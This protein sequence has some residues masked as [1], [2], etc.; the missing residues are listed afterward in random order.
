MFPGYG[1]MLEKYGDLNHF[2]SSTRYRANPQPRLFKTVMGFFRDSVSRFVQSGKHEEA[3]RTLMDKYNCDGLHILFDVYCEIKDVPLNNC[4]VSTLVDHSPFW[5]LFIDYIEEHNKCETKN[6]IEDCNRK[7][8]EELERK[9]K[10]IKDAIQDLEAGVKNETFSINGMLHFFEKLPTRVWTYMSEMVDFP[11]QTKEKIAEVDDRAKKLHY[12]ENL[13]QFSGGLLVED[14]E[15]LSKKLQRFSDD[16]ETLKMSVLCSDDYFPHAKVIDSLVGEKLL[17]TLDQ[18]ADL[19]KSRIWDSLWNKTANAFWEDNCSPE[20][21][22]SVEDI[23]EEIF[24]ETFD[25]W[26]KFRMQVIAKQVTFS[27]L[28]EFDFHTYPLQEMQNQLTLLLRNPPAS[29]EK[30]TNFDEITGCLQQFRKL[31]DGMD[32]LLDVVAFLS[33]LNLLQGLAKTDKSVEKL[34]KLSM[35]YQ[36]KVEWGKQTLGDV[37]NILEVMQEGGFILK[38]RGKQGEIKKKYL[39]LLAKHPSVVDFLTQH[40][41]EEYDDSDFLDE[42]DQMQ[43][44]AIAAYKKV[45]NTI[46][47]FILRLSE[48]SGELPISSLEEFFSLFASLR[49]RKNHLEDLEY[50]AN[51]ESI[52]AVK[53]ILFQLQH[54]STQM[55]TQ[56]MNE[57]MKTGT[58]HLVHPEHDIPTFFLVWGGTSQQQTYS[59]KEIEDL[60]NRLSL[61]LKGARMTNEEV[62]DRDLRATEEHKE[63]IE[64]LSLQYLTIQDI[65]RV[66]TQLHHMGNF[67]FAKY[68]EEFGVTEFRKNWRERQGYLKNE[69]DRWNLATKTILSGYPYLTFLS[70]EHWKKV[71]TNIINYDVDSAKAVMDFLH[72]KL[73]D[74]TGRQ[75]TRLVYYYKKQ[76]EV[77][78]RST[79]RSQYI[80]QQC[81]E[82]LDAVANI[83]TV[84]PKRRLRIPGS[85]K[86]KFIPLQSGVPNVILTSSALT[87]DI[88]TTVYASGG[89]VPCHYEIIFCSQKTSFEEVQALL[90]RFCHKE[91]KHNEWTERYEQ[92]IYCIVNPQELLLSIQCKLLELIQQICHLREEGSAKQPEQ[93]NQVDNFLVLVGSQKSSGYLL[94]ALNVYNISKNFVPLGT[95]DLHA[96]YNELAAQRYANRVLVFGSRCP[97]VGKSWN[98]RQYLKKHGCSYVHIPINSGI[99]SRD[100]IQL[101]NNQSLQPQL[102]RGFH[103]D[104]APTASSELNFQLYQLL[105]I[106][107]IA[108]SSD[109]IFSP[110]TQDIF[111]IELA[112]P[113]ASSLQKF[114]FCRG[115]PMRELTKENTL[116]DASDRTIQFVCQFLRCYSRH[117]QRF[118]ICDLD[119][120]HDVSNRA[121]TP[122]S[123]KKCWATLGEILAEFGRDINEDSL[124]TTLNFVRFLYQQFKIFSKCGFYQAEIM[125]FGEINPRL[126]VEVC[127]SL[128]ETAVEITNKAA[129]TNS[130]EDEMVSGN[131]QVSFWES[132]NHAMLLFPWNDRE[133]QSGSVQVVYKDKKLVP[134]SWLTIFKTQVLNDSYI[135]LPDYRKMDE[136]AL[137]LF[138]SEMI[139]V[140]NPKNPDSSYALT[141]DN[142]LKMIAIFIRVKASIPVIVMGDTGVGKSALIQ[143]LCK[144]S[145]IKFYSLDVHGGTTEDTICEF[146]QKPIKRAKKREVWVFFDEI[147]TCNS[148]G[149]FKQILCDHC[150]YGRP[151]P[152]NLKILA[153][154]NPYVERNYNGK[155]TGLVFHHDLFKQKAPSGTKAEEAV[156][157]SSKMKKLVYRVH[158]LPLTMVEYLWHYGQLEGEEERLYI[159]AMIRQ[160]NFTSSLMGVFRDLISVSQEFIRRRSRRQ[161]A[162]LYSA[163]LVVSMRDVRRCIQLYAW[164]M[165]NKLKLVP[166]NKDMNFTVL[167]SMLHALAICYHSRLLEKERFKYRCRITKVFN[168]KATCGLT[169]NLEGEIDGDGNTFKRIVETGQ[170]SFINHLQLPKGIAPNKA[171]Q[172]NI[173]CLAVCILNSIPIFIVG[174]PGSSKSLSMSLLQNNLNGRMSATKFLKS[175]PAVNV[176]SYQCSPLS[177]AEGIKESINK[178]KTMQKKMNE[179]GNDS[180]LYVV[181][182]DEI[183]LAEH[184][185]HLPLKVLHQLLEG[186][187]ST[188]VPVVGLTNWALDP[189]KMNRAIYIRRPEPDEKDLHE[190]AKAIVGASRGPA[191]PELV[192]KLSRL[193]KGYLQIYWSQQSASS[194]D[195]KL[196][197][198]HGLRDF[199]FFVKHIQKK[200]QA[201]QTFDEAFVDGIARNFGGLNK[202]KTKTIL[203]IFFKVIS[204]DRIPSQSR[205]LF[206]SPLRLIKENCVD[207]EGRHLMVISRVNVALNILSQHEIISPDTTDIIFGSSFPG[208]RNDTRI[209]QDITQIKHCMEVGRQ[210]VL[211]QL[212][213]LYESLYDMLNQ[214]YSRRAGKQFCRIAIGP[215]S[216]RCLVHEK[217]RLIVVAEKEDIDCGKLPPPLLNRFEKQRL[218]F[219]DLLENEEK[220]LVGSIGN[221][222][223]DYVIQQDPGKKFSFIG[224]T[225]DNVSS[226][227]IDQVKKHCALAK[228][229]S[230]KKDTEEVLGEKGKE[231]EFLISEDVDEPGKEIFLKCLRELLLTATPDGI[232][233]ASHTSPKFSDIKEIYFLEQPH[234]SLQSLF[235]HIEK[236]VSMFPVHEEHPERRWLVLSF[237]DPT[238][239][240]KLV[241]DEA[242]FL[243]LEDYSREVDFTFKIKTFFSDLSCELEDNMHKNTLIIQCVLADTP[244]SVLWHT[245]HIIQN[246]CAQNRSFG[247]QAVVLF[248]VHTNRSDL[249]TLLIPH[250]PSWNTILISELKQCDIPSIPKMLGLDLLQLIDNQEGDITLKPN[251]GFLET[252]FLNNFRGCL[253][254][255]NYPNMVEYKDQIG[256]LLDLLQND[257]FF[258]DVLKKRV[259]HLLRQ[260]AFQLTQ[261][262]QIDVA[263]DF[264]QIAI[265]GSYQKALWSKIVDQINKSLAM[266][267][268]HSD[269]NFN[270]SCYFDALNDN[271]AGKIKLWQ[272]LFEDM[273]RFESSKMDGYDV[274]TDG[275]SNF[276]HGGFFCKFPFSY[277]FYEQLEGM[278]NELTICSSAVPLGSQI[279]RHQL[280]ELERLRKAM[281]ESYPDVLVQVLQQEQCGI[282]GGNCLTL[283]YLHDFIRMCNISTQ[284]SDFQDLEYIIQECLIHWHSVFVTDTLPGQNHFEDLATVHYVFW[285]CE[286]KVRALVSLL[287]AFVWLLPSFFDLC[288]TVGCDSNKKGMKGM[289]EVGVEQRHNFRDFLGDTQTNCFTSQ[290]NVVKDVE[291]WHS[292]LSEVLSKLFK[293]IRDIILCYNNEQV[294]REIDLHDMQIWFGVGRKGGVVE[295]LLD[296]IGNKKLWQEWKH[297]VVADK[298]FRHVL[299]PLQS[300]VPKIVETWHSVVLGGFLTVE[301]K[302]RNWAQIVESLLTTNNSCLDSIRSLAVDEASAMIVEQGILTFLE[303]MIDFTT[304]TFQKEYSNQG[305]AGTTTDTLPDEMESLVDCVLDIITLDVMEPKKDKT[306]KMDKGK[307][308]ALDNGAMRI[309]M[310]NKGK[311]K[312]SQNKEYFFKASP[313][314]KALLLHFLLDGLLVARSKVFERLEAVVHSCGYQHQFCLLYVQYVEDLLAHEERTKNDEQKG[315][316]FVISVGKQIRESTLDTLTIKEFLELI[317]KSRFFVRRFVQVYCEKTRE[318]KP[319]EDRVEILFIT[320]NMILSARANNHLRI[321]ALK[322]FEVLVGGA[323]LEGLD[324]KWMS[325]L[326]ISQLRNTGDPFAPMF[327]SWK[328]VQ[329]GQVVSYRAIHTVLGDCL[330]AKNTDTTC[331]ELLRRYFHPQEESEVSDSI[332][333]GQCITLSLFELC[334]LQSHTSFKSK[335]V[336]AVRQWILQEMDADSVFDSS[337]LYFQLL[338]GITT[339]QLLLR[340][341]LDQDKAALMLGV[342]MHLVTLVCLGSKDTVLYQLYENPSFFVNSYFPC[343]PDDV[344]SIVLGALKQT[345][346]ISTW[347]CPNGHKYVIGECGRPAQISKCPCGA[348]I[349]GTSHVPTKQCRPVNN[350]RRN[351]PPKGYP[352]FSDSP[353]LSWRLLN[354]TAYRV[355]MFFVH[356]ILCVRAASS[357]EGL[358]NVQKLIG[359]GLQRNNTVLFLQTILEK[360]W[361]MIGRLNGNMN[362]QNIFTILN[363]TLFSLSKALD[364]TDV[365][366]LLRT[367]QHRED[368][369]IQ[370]KD[371]ICPHFDQATELYAVCISRKIDV[372]SSRS[373]STG[374]ALQRREKG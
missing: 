44:E 59:P 94:S 138:L 178:A 200:L 124:V 229:V 70:Q 245:K 5:T 226:V 272:C 298:L 167:H 116:I 221:W 26:T 65:D 23:V 66:L 309:A 332:Y 342:A 119:Q 228:S 219:S 16:K 3:F 76:I 356:S 51:E 107:A 235:F 15:V 305:K 32:T 369:E 96:I 25:E 168:Q 62:D 64:Q 188:S 71:V 327:T 179:G 38:G 354:P 190:T 166:R 13:C 257:Q 276:E 331:D 223:E 104:I 160:H 69:L 147:N 241:P 55:A 365:D 280:E 100:L 256:M 175:L 265:D 232:V 91:I 240:D 307:G 206:F 192:R 54:D 67:E 236:T 30:A 345:D 103:I 362:N 215:H 112:S 218:G 21:Q 117:K 205:K 75:F 266:V 196:E 268:K 129:K 284:F 122:L 233:R 125:K 88:V 343:G 149:F 4:N 18:L 20:E 279:A 349:G 361:D 137:F 151:L 333:I 33:H 258:V 27:E 120:H 84:R 180:V 47:D 267:L 352:A 204:Q 242:T 140:F 161:D 135:S 243:K 285:Q 199:Y 28:F 85:T 11:A 319:L 81:G 303:D 336:E 288:H 287:D 271:Y 145:S 355:I 214:H 108:N 294:G 252:V 31:C 320:A 143:Y 370:L 9:L 72:F 350:M 164:F 171:L 300:S 213:N 367:E 329:D 172:E 111:C 187:S 162:D 249:D 234:D 49:I 230:A 52:A 113:Q 139:G 244:L 248:V 282:Q 79:T 53:H 358:E 109:G 208:D 123:S 292:I 133:G 222:L 63:H 102:G 338:A 291:R 41:M 239:L 182:L 335:R 131:V 158:P 157:D 89:H 90:L 262:W 155:Q 181:V 212:E 353:T 306:K 290:G 202:D 82:F 29:D 148:M 263:F 154:C 57:I 253:S 314:F 40:D 93:S 195:R 173:F 366:P 105:F 19:D 251:E 328:K 153:A 48:N 322:Q 374:I 324:F 121:V 99:S 95:D 316:E 351:P 259:C 207:L 6:E 334:Q 347:A 364:T 130:A 12:F 78:E 186:N 286:S 269:R 7:R 17:S 340:N 348:E 278:K 363:K 46:K 209:V 210:V 296:Q 275:N 163:S 261:D 68:H 227:V 74:P 92:P 43:V 141:L 34:I 152:L 98:I 42:A 115:L 310:K 36:D 283:D 217:F 61:S 60:R 189:A 231:K 194:P 126:R 156:L 132:S 87:L 197:D 2:F 56:V 114:H 339:K 373:S 346:R 134:L 118:L 255:L 142:I 97:G 198:F 1:T 254:Q 37:P 128:I 371:L 127:R 220:E 250:D 150:L 224:F 344:D 80:L 191:S 159:K 301:G 24:P 247:S 144:L 14:L 35:L 274:V 302:Q 281:N 337:P 293:R 170:M 323:A 8:F 273:D 270:L 357:E 289:I 203:D 45:N 313:S 185:P 86:R 183:G 304:Y 177:T 341:A 326:P 308:R 372:E 318:R 39:K 73:N 246:M 264:R 238:V 146:L 50:F 83:S 321:F 277:L 58:Y 101:I 237:S 315:Y 136:K 165:E 359:T 216:A 174:K 299:Y 201:S 169:L 311:E 330:Q 77:M 360:N 368:W 317:G 110:Q 211:L 10:P 184:S 295:E 22:I 176:F 225:E 325:M 312:V 193:A 106:G 260:D 297:L